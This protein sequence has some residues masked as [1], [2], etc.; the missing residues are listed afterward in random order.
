MFFFFKVHMVVF[1]DVTEDFYLCRK[2]GLFETFYQVVQKV[3]V[4]MASRWDE[5][6]VTFSRKL[7]TLHAMTNYTTESNKNKNKNK[8]TVTILP[9]I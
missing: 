5:R 8:I 4:K 1:A 9:Y 3:F 2:K 7:S 6:D